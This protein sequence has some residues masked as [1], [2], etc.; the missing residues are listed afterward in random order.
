MKR[1]NTLRT[2][3][4]L[5][6]AGLLLLVVS[7]LGIYVYGNMARGLRD[8]ADDSLA[9][10]ASQVSA[11]LEIVAGQLVFAENFVEEPENADLRERGFTVRILSLQGQILQEFG[12]D[13]ALLVSPVSPF[14]TPTFATLTN[15]A[16]RRTIRALTAPVLEEG[17]LVA[18]L[19]VA[20]SLEDI[21]DTLGRL[22]ATLLVSVPL[23]VGVAGV[24]GYFLAARA[25]APIDRL[26]RRA[27]RISAEDLSARL[28]LP[29]TDDE[30][31][32]LAETLDA[33][34]A[35][36]EDSFQRERQ[37]VADAS[38]E[39][40]TPLAAMQA[41]LNLTR[42]K[43]RSPEEYEGA[44]ADLAE[45]TDRLLALAEDLLRLARARPHPLASPERIDLSTLLRD[46]ADSMRPLAEAKALTLCCQAPEG[47]TMLGDRDDL[48][49]LFVLLLDN[50]IKYTEYGGVTLSAARTQAQDLAV[51]VADTG[52]GISPNHLPKLFDRF[53]RVDPSRTNPGAGLGLALALEIV[54]AHG[55][56]IEVNSAVGKG[57]QFTV[58]LPENGGLAG[59]KLL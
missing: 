31:G 2:R 11:G 14:T 43:R 16:D 38:H 55:G 51:Q 12:P 24:S 40:R 58:T 29:A 47:L 37:F 10:A 17:R 6:T 53:Y 42:E 1:L 35:R 32:R 34:L 30:V 56:G 33:M 9:L 39:L 13:R 4:A 46:V 3:F 36:L 21:E 15:S 18:L 20:K 41:I 25:L 59:I 54:S 52:I 28:S 49:R 44:L 26:T 22:R 23:L 27:R 5:W 48:I 8:G 45:E 50:A 57:T 7:L 19:Q